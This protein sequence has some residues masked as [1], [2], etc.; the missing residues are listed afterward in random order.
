MVVAQ[1]DRSPQ[2]QYVGDGEFLRMREG[3]QGSGCTQGGKARSS[4]LMKTEVRGAP[5][6]DNLDPLPEDPA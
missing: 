2:Q 4:A 1:L 6:P 5:V 3:Q